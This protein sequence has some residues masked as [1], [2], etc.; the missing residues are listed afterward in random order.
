MSIN[1]P[2]EFI[3]RM[4]SDLGSDFLAFRDTYEQESVYSIRL[5]PLKIDL[6]ME[7]SKTT[8]TIV[9]KYSTGE[10]VTWCNTGF[11]SLPSL[12]PGS[13]AYHHAGAIYIQEASAM[14]AVPQ[15]DVSR[16]LKV[17][18]MC[19]APG[20][21]STQIAGYLMQE[22]LLVCNEPV[23]NRAKILSENIERLGVK[24]AIVTNEYPNKLAKKLPGYFDRILIDAPCSGEGMFRKNPDACGE[25]SPGEVELCAQRDDELLDLADE[26][27][28][29]GGRIVFSTCTFA[30][31][32][33]EE[34]IE[35]FLKRHP[36]YECVYQHKLF[37][38]EA[39]GEGHFVAALVKKS[40]EDLEAEEK[41]KNAVK[42]LKSGNV[43]TKDYFKFL[44]ETFV[45]EVA[46]KYKDK[47]R[48]FQVEDRIYYL[49]E[50]CF[51]FNGL[52]VLRAGLHM[53]NILKGRFEPSH[54]LAHASKGSE[55]K[56]S[57]SFA[58]GSAE[59][60]GYLNGQTI[61]CDSSLKGWTLISVD[62]VSL[63]W[64]K[65]VNGTIKN[66]YPKGLR[67]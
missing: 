5:N 23:G 59:I 8:Q 26:M 51:D 18:D 3:E 38:H 44:D 13:S 4:K 14:S 2:E 7:T 55:L 40:V 67:K 39:K 49:P 35:R 46:K 22:G 43:D 30:R 60:A 31:P 6:S 61:S 1:L 36:E 28:A 58:E 41:S 9:E 42:L 16:G 34:S 11:Y 25:W 45:D 32:E 33:D 20:G 50:K 56:S 54:A 47:T 66:H 27:L 63:G 24:N 57:V 12:A 53:G 15:L 65:A 64:G 21:K 37:P 62:E 29:D 52:H 17:F 19:A 10:Q 48:L